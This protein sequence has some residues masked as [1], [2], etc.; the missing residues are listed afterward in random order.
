MA[1]AT[2]VHRASRDEKNRM[3]AEVDS[4]AEIEQELGSD[5]ELYGVA[6]EEVEYKLE[7][8]GSYRPSWQV[9]VYVKEEFKDAAGFY[10][11]SCGEVGA[12]FPGQ[13]PGCGHCWGEWEDTGIF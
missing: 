1:T 2:V 8:R 10:R 7:R 13:V 9:S 12:L 5:A 3:Q 11:C 6:P 4:M